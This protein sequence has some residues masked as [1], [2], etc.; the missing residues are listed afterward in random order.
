MTDELADIDAT[1]RVARPAPV[2]PPDVPPLRRDIVDIVQDRGSAAAL[3][4]FF[5]EKDLLAGLARWFGRDVLHDAKRW[6]DSVITALERDIAEIDA[7]IGRQVDAI[8]H[9]PRFQALE[10]RWRG[11][12]YLAGLVAGDG[13]DKVVLR[14]LNVSW[15]EM[16]HDFSRA[17]DFDR[18]HLFEKIYSD[19]FG[20]PGGRPYGLLVVDHK[21]SHVRLPGLGTDDVGALRALAQIAAAAFAPTI[22]GAHPTLFGLDSFAQLGGPFELGGVF[23]APEYRR[24]LDLQESEDAGFLGVALPGILMRPPWPDDGARRDGFRYHEG[25]H[26][27]AHDDYLWGNAGFAFAAVA[28]R[29]FLNYGWFADIRGVRIDAE[30]GGVVTGLPSLPAATDRF[31]AAR[32][33]PVEAEMTDGQSQELSNLGFIGLSACRH[34]GN[35]AFLSNQSVR[36]PGAQTGVAL[37][38]AQLGGMLQYVLCVSRFT[39]YIKVMAR[40][41]LGG[42]TTAE[43][44][45]D[46][47]SEWLR[48]YSLGNDDASAEQKARYPLRESSVQITPIPGQPGK[49]SCVVHLRPHFQLDNLVAGFRLRTEMAAPLA[50]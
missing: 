39:H 28:I 20:M 15:P 50:K 12:D 43:Q 9:H 30:D 6:R 33:R 48:Q 36:R 24:W 16:C 4:L 7:L 10:A 21:F 5:G 19:E 11:V 49:L 46:Y 17:A 27:L 3:D 22:L 2:R 13:E 47:L 40:D 42:F 31:A 35:L 8:L 1:I 18:S 44:I 14:L 45:E 38:N 23:R 29:S 41:R 32:R 37:A 25:A 26:G 34:T